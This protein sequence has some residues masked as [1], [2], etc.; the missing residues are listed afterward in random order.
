MIKNIKING[1]KT[2]NKF[3]LQLTDLNVLFGPNAAGKSNFLD[4]LQLISR[5]VGSKTLKDAFDPPYR[6]K[7]IESFTLPL[8]GIE[9]LLDQEIVKCDF[10]LDVQLSEDIIR[11]VNKEINEMRKGL[12]GNEKESEYIKEKL[13]RYT[14]E[15][16]L[17]PKQ[18]YL[19]VCNESL[20]A[21]RQN[22]KAK[23]S[24]TAFLEKM[25]TSRLSLRMEGQAHPTYFDLGL[26]YS[27]LSK[28]LYAPHYPHITAFVKELQSWRFF[29][30]EP[31]E[32]MRAS[33]P[34]KEVRH[35]GMMGEE[36]AAYLHGLKINPE[37]QKRFNSICKAVKIIIPSIEK[38]ETDIDKKTG[39][40]ELY[41]IENGRPISSRLI[42]EGTLRLLGLLSITGDNDNPSLICFEEPENGIHPRKIKLIAEYLKNIA[43][44][45]SQIIVTTHSP[46]FPDEIN[47]ENLFVCKKNNGI[48]SITPYHE[49]GLLKKPGINQA[50]DDEP[51]PSERIMRGDLDE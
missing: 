18:G 28:S 16:E 48:S 33:S 50:L 32:R 2:F 36:L 5:I 46:I 31:R 1:Y 26:D 8:R 24:R 10:I 11:Q 49:I 44:Q 27:A 7:P 45:N 34:I 22:L 19:R 38:I 29:Y 42:S 13:L 35:I 15:I 21:L 51:L 23:E 17:L 14:L 6:G 41:L 3:S 40:V 9:G 20:R 25:D 43:N 12:K 37:K 4:A 30:F 47:N 39:D